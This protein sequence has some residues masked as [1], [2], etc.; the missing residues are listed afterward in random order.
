MPII[1]Y[2][3]LGYRGLNRNTCQNFQTIIFL[4]LNVHNYV[5]LDVRP[6]FAPPGLP[7]SLSKKERKKIALLQKSMRVLFKIGRKHNQSW[8]WATV[9]YFYSF[10]MEKLAIILFRH[11]RSHAAAARLG[12]SERYTRYRTTDAM[13]SSSHVG[14]HAR[15]AEHVSLRYR[16]TP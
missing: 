5:G 14:L 15:R 11:E 16:C 13:P 1:G 6:S 12:R 2:R 3:D 10:V 4:F 9:E 7:R 8:K